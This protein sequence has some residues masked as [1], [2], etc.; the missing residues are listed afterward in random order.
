MKNAV[1]GVSRN[2]LVPVAP[3]DMQPVP[4]GAIL[5]DL[6][7]SDGAFMCRVNGEWRL[8]EDW[9]RPVALG[10][11]IEWYEV[12]Q[13][14]GGLRTVLQIVITVIA[15]MIAGPGGFYGVQGAF[16]AAAFQVFGNLILTQIFAEDAAVRKDQK[17][18]PTY[19]TGLSGNR[20]RLFEPIPKICGR[21]QTFPP[22]ASQPYY[23][24]DAYGRDAEN[25]ETGGDQYY[26]A[27][28]AVGVGDHTI[29]RALIDDTTI[30][31]FADVLTARYLPPG[32]M[33][34]DVNPAVVTAPE[35]TGQELASSIYVGGF[36]VV[37]PK[38]TTGKI[39]YDIVAPEG[40]G[41]ADVNGDWMN[42]SASWRVEVR[43]LDEFGVAITP[44]EIIENRTMTDATAR[45][46][47][48]TFSL[49]L[50]RVMRPE[51]RL[52]RTDLKSES[53]RARHT[54]VW[55]S[56]RAFLAEPI[57]L[58]PNVAHYELV[59]RSSEQLSQITQGRFSL[60][61]WGHARPLGDVD[62]DG[63]PL[64]TDAK[65]TR[66]PATWLLE[67]ATNPVWGLGYPEQ[68]IDF[69]AFLDLQAITDA[70]QD[71]FDFVFD[72]STDAW[73]AMQI[74]ARSCRSR[75]FRRGG[76]LTVARDQWEPLP[77][78]AFTH[79]NA[80]QMTTIERLPTPETPDGLIVEYFDNRSWQWLPIECPAPGVESMQNPLR[81][82]LPGVTGPTHAK[83]E[84]LYEAAQNMLRTRTVTCVTEMEG[85]LPAYMSPVKWLPDIPGYGQTGD[86]T[87]F[88]PDSLTMRLS[89]PPEWKEGAALHIS[90]RGPDGAF[91]DPIAITPGADT[92]EVVLGEPL[93]FELPALDDG[94][95]ERPTFLLGPVE[96]T[97][98]LVKIISIGDAGLDDQGV[99]RFNITGVIDDIRI[100]QADNDYLPAPG[101][102]QDPI[103]PADEVPEGNLAVIPRLSGQYTTTAQF[104]WGVERLG[105][106]FRNDGRLVV[107]VLAPASGVPGWIET[108]QE[109]QWLLR[110]PAEVAD[111]SRYEIMWDW[112][113]QGGGGV[114]TWDIEPGQWYNLGTNRYVEVYCFTPSQ[115]N[116]PSFWFGWWT[117]Q[118]REIATG[119]VQAS[120][121]YEI[122]IDNSTG[123]T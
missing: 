87:E 108:E 5:R 68:R 8:Q 31:H 11:V 28:F 25:K 57:P 56:L 66:N 94:V 21:H 90:V 48:W 121:T 106:L 84:G 107:R 37:G 114:L 85:I 69:R 61:A 113:L 40:L 119:I 103:D 55:A 46:R 9:D 104:F 75:V 7:P 83:R 111:T 79:S 63:V 20:A 13:G 14:K 18:S 52:V 54:I 12:P 99:Q 3:R 51:L 78:T 86:V 30:G 43:E 2:P 96:T 77:V 36:A 35:V 4:V 102:I 80:Q 65:A 71:R 100:H 32:T 110:P 41:I 91:S 22:F 49:D 17:D 24:Y 115:M 67:L 1:V 70:R 10:D 81:V 62:P 45:P 34:T 116:T 64:W 97:S 39:E 15:S 112:S 74:I 109:G 101:E 29:E 33:P 76:V 23:R 93:P 19:G 105:F 58:N 50:P 82:R 53:N 16:A 117:F 88:D 26:Y 120:A 6:R 38:R 95:R 59:M 72:A 60:I 98:E 118:I 123:G 42:Y 92:L 47:R 44:W 73:A 27:L 89:E 122:R